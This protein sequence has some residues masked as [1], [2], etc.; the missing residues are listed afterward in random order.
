MLERRTST[1]Q[2]RQKGSKEIFLLLFLFFAM[3]GLHCC[4]GFA[5]A[6]ERG[7]YFGFGAQVLIAVA[8]LTAEHGALGRSGFS[9]AVPGL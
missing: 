8:S 2:G 4:M 1:L 6:E 9:I 5:L 7:G 3:L